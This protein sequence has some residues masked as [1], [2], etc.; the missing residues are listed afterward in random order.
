MAA[1][2]AAELDRPLRLGEVL[3]AGIRIFATRPIPF[4]LVGC[5]EGLVLLAANSVH[6]VAGICI[7]AVSFAVAF[8]VVTRLVVGDEQ[9]QAWVRATHAVPI[10][11]VLAFIVAVPFYLGF[12]AG[13]I[14][15]LFSAAW[16]G[17]T[18]FAIP[19]AMLE[20]P[21][22]PGFA[23][24]MV[25][26]LRRTAV[27]ARVEYLHAAG[28][29]AALIVVYILFSVA[30]A[31]ALSGYADNSRLVAQALAQIVLAPFFF[32]GL[33]VL[34]FDQR[35]RALESAGRPGGRG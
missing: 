14:L 17:L 3:A 1:P 20:D 31:A 28:V 10:L 27:L 23:G 6:I 21:P 5:L 22:L 4:L 2:E 16:L 9:R 35:A 18:A 15:L 12:V 7:L 32:I 30:L 26:A 24:R 25:H 11:A 8:A 34:Y 19:A 29:A 33:S 13:L